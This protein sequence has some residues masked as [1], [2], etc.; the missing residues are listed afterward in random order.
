ML[1]GAMESELVIRLLLPTSAAIIS[2][3]RTKQADKHRDRGNSQVR[4]IATP[5]QTSQTI[6][7]IIHCHFRIRTYVQ[8]RHQRFVSF[9][10]VTDQM[11]L[12]IAVCRI[13]MSTWATIVL[14]TVPLG[15]RNLSASRPSRS[16]SVAVHLYRHLLKKIKQ[17]PWSTMLPGT[18]I[19]TS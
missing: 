11:H 15:L 1:C 18:L 13:Y 8:T 19:S 9:G 12:T 17:P 2:S 3:Y 7:M 4:C 6:G 5:I 10:F 14:P 16:N